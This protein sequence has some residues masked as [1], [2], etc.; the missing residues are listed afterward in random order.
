VKLDPNVPEYLKID[1]I[2]KMLGRYLDKD[3]KE[4]SLLLYEKIAINGTR[5]MMSA[6][7]RLSQNVFERS[8]WYFLLS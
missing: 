4:P 1:L 2:Q 7:Q 8:S 5:V 3:E 6:I